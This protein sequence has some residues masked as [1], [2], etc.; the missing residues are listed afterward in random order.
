MA[1]GPPILGTETRLA[2]PHPV[3]AAIPRAIAG[4]HARRHLPHQ[5]LSGPGA[6]IPAIR[7]S[8]RKSS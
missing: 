3:S 2:E 6:T 4:L 8:P 1:D 7:C 5:T